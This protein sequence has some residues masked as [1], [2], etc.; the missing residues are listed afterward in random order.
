MTEWKYISI[1]FTVKVIAVSIETAHARIF[2]P[3]REGGGGGG[4]EGMSRDVAGLR[5]PP[6]LHTHTHM[7]Q[8]ADC[9]GAP[10]INRECQSDG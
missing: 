7:L 3:H 9:S 8:V 4:V 5:D 6:L 2:F 10:S 1:T